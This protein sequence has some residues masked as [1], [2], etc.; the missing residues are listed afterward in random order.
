[1][2]P[3]RFTLAAGSAFVLA[4]CG[5]GGDGVT[6]PPTPQVASVVI[7]APSAAPTFGTLGRTVQFAAQ[8]RDAAGAAVSGVTLTWASSNSSVA[9]ISAAG[10]VTAVANGT[11]TVTAAGGGRTSAGVT[12]TVTQVPLTAVVSPA[13]PTIGALGSTRQFTVQLRDSA[14]NALP[15]ATPV[16]WTVTN[17]GTIS[18]SPAGLVTALA[19]SPPGQA[20]SLLVSAGSPAVSTAT[21]VLVTQVPASI[22]VGVPAG[23]SVLRT[24]GRTRQLTA[25][26]RDSNAN[27]LVT[28]PTIT[29]TST[30]G[31]VATVSGTGLVTAVGDGTSTIQAAVGTVTATRT[32]IVAR[33]PATL[34]VSPTSG[35]I[36]TSGG[37]LTVNGTAQDSS[38]ANLALAWSSSNAAL[39]AVN[40]AAGT[41]P[42]AT[43]ASVPANTFGPGTAYVRLVVAGRRDSSAV[44]VNIPASFATNV[45]PIFTA[46][47]AVA[48]CHTGA[49]PSGSMNLSAG[50]AY[51]QLVGV[52][53]FDQPPGGGAVRVIAGDAG[54]SYLIRKLEGGPNITGSRMPNGQP[55]LPQAT[56]NI[57]RSWITQGALNN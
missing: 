33:F 8:A 56:V 50:S 13:N 7:T 25:T 40:P 38:G 10:L 45:Q 43:T 20:D 32:Q 21:A 28:Q 55:P 46:S 4:S 9:S 52:A 6:P 29:W 49:V 48:G 22:A 30:A 57:I 14:A 41:S 24:T 31:G 51:A 39:V 42:G 34:S 47:C 18:V 23:D 11:T 27:A 35:S 19:V 54:N 15:S 3:H 17:R 26:V 2:R 12:V 37:T 1:M 16:T 44:T 36:T 53:V 5:G